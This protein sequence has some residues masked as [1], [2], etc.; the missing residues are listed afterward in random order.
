MR[1]GSDPERDLH[2]R[3]HRRREPS[4]RPRAAARQGAGDPRPAR[5][6]SRAADDARDAGGFA[7]FA[8]VLV[9]AIVTHAWRVGEL[10]LGDA[11]VTTLLWLPL[12]VGRD[13]LL[14]LPFA[15]VPALLLRARLPR[16]AVMVPL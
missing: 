6:T 11:R 3:R 10:V 12:L 1:R 9:A 2:G 5:M 13:L 8:F 14:A 15:V 16:R 7:L 4:L